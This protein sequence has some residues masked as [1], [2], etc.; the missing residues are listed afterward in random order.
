MPYHILTTSISPDKPRSLRPCLQAAGDGSSDAGPSSVGAA[1]P[2]ESLNYTAKCLRS[3]SAQRGGANRPQRERTAPPRSSAR[4]CR[5]S[6][7]ARSRAPSRVRPGSS[8]GSCRTSQPSGGT[9]LPGREEFSPG[10][11]SAQIGKGGCARR[12][13]PL[14]GARWERLRGAVGGCSGLAAVITLL[15]LDGAE[16]SRVLPCVLSFWFKMGT[17]NTESS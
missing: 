9:S 8:R 16:Q 10:T 17:R 12:G 14:A 11:R 5:R 1:F 4:G 15:W 6:P 3:G 2:S 7:A 13:V